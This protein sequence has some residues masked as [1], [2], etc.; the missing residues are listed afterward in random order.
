MMAV[1]LQKRDREI[2]KFVYAFRV[3]SFAQI[4]GRYFKNIFRTVGSRRIRQLTEAGYLRTFVVGEGEFEYRYVRLTD[5][6]WNEIRELWPFEIDNPHLKSESPIH[7]L[8]LADLFSSFERLSSFNQ[9]MTENLLQS[10]SALAEDPKFG[11]LAKLQADGALILTPPNSET[12]VYGVELETSK[13]APDRYCDKLLNYYIATGLD[14]VLYIADKQATLDAVA[15]ADADVRSN[16]ESILHFALEKDVLAS[17]GRINFKN[18]TGA[19]IE[20][21]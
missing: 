10:S 21:Y 11:A 9:L 18:V 14:G 3:S 5:K 16:R 4:Q 2:L 8:R 19:E 13:K 12:Y 17:T 20:L 15:R 1:E 7:D 6:G